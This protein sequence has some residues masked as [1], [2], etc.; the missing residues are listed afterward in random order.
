MRSGPRSH[1][2]RTDRRPPH[3][4]RP[5]DWG[6]R[7]GEPE[8]PVGLDVVK[9]FREEQLGEGMRASEWVDLLAHPDR[10]QDVVDDFMH[11][12]ARPRRRTPRFAAVQ[13]DRPG[14]GLAYVDLPDDVGRIDVDDVSRVIAAI[15]KSIAISGRP[16]DERAMAEEMNDVRAVLCDGVEDRRLVDDVADRH[17]KA[18]G[19]RPCLDAGLD[20]RIATS[21]QPLDVGSTWGPTPAWWIAASSSASHSSSPL[22]VTWAAEMTRQDL[23][24]VARAGHRLGQGTELATRRGR[25]ID[26]P[27]DRPAGL[28]GAKADRVPA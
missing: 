14:R 4:W 5:L 28:E 26:Q 12:R 20:G 17:R 7:G 8:R 10:E 6:R 19:T 22:K 27:G 13:R 15:M 18:V 11:E 16:P 24:W 9:E 21:Y 23:R 2:S 25:A 1:V 3:H